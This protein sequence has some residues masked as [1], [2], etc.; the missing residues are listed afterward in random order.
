ML[1]EEDVEWTIEP[2]TPECSDATVR[3]R[4]TNRFQYIMTDKVRIAWIE[5]TEDRGRAIAH[6]K[7]IA[8]DCLRAFSKFRDE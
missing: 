6:A 8:L 2:P 7:A 3:G 4:I 1:R 5:W